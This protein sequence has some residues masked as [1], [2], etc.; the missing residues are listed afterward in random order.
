MESNL[1]VG[2]VV[3]C[4]ITG[5]A[6]YG[7]FVKIGNDINGLIHISEICSR[8]IN[9]LNTRYHVNQFIKARIIEIDYEKKQVRLSLNKLKIRKNSL[10]EQGHGFEP[11]K[12]NLNLWIVERMDE[13]KKRKKTL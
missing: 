1:L 5:I 9:D 2:D 7:I 13:I 4:Q 6:N 11:L 3:E 12:E 8:Y 10:V